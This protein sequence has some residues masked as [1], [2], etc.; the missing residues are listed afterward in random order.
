MPSPG[1]FGVARVSRHHT[2]TQEH[3]QAIQVHINQ[4]LRL[5]T[6]FVSV[7]ARISSLRECESKVLCLV[8]GSRV[9]QQVF[10]CAGPLE[11]LVARRHVIDPPVWCGAATTTLYGG[12]GDPL[13]SVGKH[14][15][16]K[17]DQ[18]DRNCVHGRDSIAG[19]RYSL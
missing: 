11:H 1:H 8:A 5:S 10:R 14:L 2:H 17:W 6:S 12:R 18:G 7:S 4:I 13:S 9:N 15:S 3:L 19:K 16:G